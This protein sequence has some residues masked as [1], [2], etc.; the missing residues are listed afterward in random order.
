MH[1][2]LAESNNTSNS[3]HSNPESKMEL[4]PAIFPDSYD[5]SPV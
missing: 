1:E 3:E 4:C 2:Q 5:S